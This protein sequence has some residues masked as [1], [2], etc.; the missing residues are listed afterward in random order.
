[1]SSDF[2]K[3]L[4]KVLC[5][6]LPSVFAQ[7][8]MS[9][10]LRFIGK[11]FPEDSTMAIK[12]AVLILLFPEGNSLGTVFIERNKYPGAHSGQISFPGGKHEREDNSLMDT[13]I[14]EAKEEIGIDPEEIRI[15]GS[16]T[17]LFVP[18]S[19]FLIYPYIG[20][21]D[22]KPVFI[23]EPKEVNSIIEIGINSL[24]DPAN[25][26]SKLIKKN[27]FSILAPYYDAKGHHIWGATAMILSEFYEILKD[28]NLLDT[29]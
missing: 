29:E 27:D 9:P 16:L 13:A 15:I 22:K 17:K 21:I 18:V 24:F 11:G 19:N 23:P 7:Q 14:R 1:M 28:G 10:T 3:R 25:K 20:L 6:K 2:E 4:E 12:S 5:G 26:K 8:K